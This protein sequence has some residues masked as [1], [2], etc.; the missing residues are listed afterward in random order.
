MLSI[1]L[2]N[3]NNLKISL[4]KIIFICYVTYID[5]RFMSYQ[6]RKKHFIYGYVASDMVKDHSDSEKK[7]Q[8]LPLQ[9]YSF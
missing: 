6:E 1:S 8:L 4:Y 7:H 3:N 9:D 5:S 2:N